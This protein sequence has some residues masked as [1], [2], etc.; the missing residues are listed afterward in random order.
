MKKLATLLFS[1]GA[2]LLMMFGCRPDEPQPEPQPKPD[3]AEF[4]FTVTNTSK[5]GTSFS[6]KPLDKETPY[7]VMIVDKA[8]FDSFATVD[9]YIDD[10]MAYLLKIAE[11]SDMSLG[12]LLA[13]MLVVGDVTDSIDGLSPD[14]EYVLYAYHMTYAGEVISDLAQQV[15]KTEGYVFNNDTFEVEVSDITYTSALI[16]ITPSNTSTPYFVN[17]VSEEDLASYGGGTE[18]YVTHLEMLRDYYLSFGKTPEE[19]IANLCFVGKKALTINNLIAGGKYYAYAMSVDEE[20]YVCSEVAQTAFTTPVPATSDLSFEVDVEEIFYDH[21]TGVVTP[22]N[23]DPYICSIQLA[24]SLSWYESDEAYMASLVDELN[25]WYGGV[26]SAIRT[27]ATDLSS[28]VGLSPETDYVVICFG[29]NGAPNTAL[30]TYEFTT[31]AANGNPENLVVEF[32]ATN[33]THNSMTVLYT[34]SEGVYYFA[35][36]AD[37]VVVDEYISREGSQEAAMI[38]LANDDIDYG[39]D[40]FGCTRV[41]YLYDLGAA[42]GRTSIPYNQLTPSTE[43]VAYA[44]AVDMETGELAS[45]KV[46]VSDVIR[47]QEKIVSDATVDFVF[48]DYYDGTALA[49]LD[50]SQ[51]NNCRGQVVVPYTVSVNDAAVAWYTSFSMGDYTEWGCSDDDIYA[52]LI[53]YGVE[54]GSD[55]VS[56][57]VKGGVAVLTY[58]EPFSFLAIAE[59]ANGNFGVGTLEVVR[60]SKDGVSPAEEFIASLA[61]QLPAKAPA[62]AAAASAHRKAPIKRTK[63][64][65][66]GMMRKPALEKATKQTEPAKANKVASGKRFMVGR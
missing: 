51:F 32:E 1:F 48:G 52:E 9:D 8:T 59:D 66:E 6:V 39:A 45:T 64:S 43:Y 12:E 28:F 40:W 2:L 11:S 17:V 62:K 24:E 19:M 31:S 41:E 57:N 25:W 16:T 44:V 29:Y 23:N 53:T 21:I 10:D 14:T 18:A 20:F 13:D 36:L 5:S 27:G 3:E 58:D 38:A 33:I 30:H 60:F 34:P 22:S 61:A 35:S 49:E 26:E 42:I 37:K 56:T 7:L 15:F 50:A 54:W 65:T 63:L 4:V 46:S 55:L 47:T